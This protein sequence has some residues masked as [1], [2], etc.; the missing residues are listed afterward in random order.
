[1]HFLP[2]KSLA[3]ILSMFNLS[4]SATLAPWPN[5]FEESILE[6]HATEFFR[7]EFWFKILRQ[8]TTRWAHWN[9]SARTNQRHAPS[10]R[11]GWSVGFRPSPKQP[12]PITI[13]DNQWERPWAFVFNL[14]ISLTTYSV[15]YS[16]FFLNWCINVILCVGTLWHHAALLRINF[17]CRHQYKNTFFVSLL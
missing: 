4:V 1:M 6:I 9:E 17:M 15:I 10:H 16:I 14:R 13:Q 2:S 11:W 3:M 5:T 7:T 8:P 12:A